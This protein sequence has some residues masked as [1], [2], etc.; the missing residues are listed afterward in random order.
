MAFNKR[1]TETEVSD[2]VS[3]K[4][5]FTHVLD[6]DNN[7]LCGISNKSIC[8]LNGNIIA[9]FVRKERVERNTPIQRVYES[10]YGEFVFFNNA[11][12]LNGNKVGYVRKSNKKSSIILL[13]TIAAIL[14]LVFTTVALIDT[15]NDDVPII[16]LIDKEGIIEDKQEIAVFDGMIKPGSQGVYYFNIYNPHY[17]ILE[18]SFSIKEYTNSVPVSNFPMQYKIRMNNMYII[19]ESEWIR[20]D[21]L[22]FTNLTIAERSTQVF[23]LEWRWPYSTDDELD[24]IFGIAAGTY[25]IQVSFTA[26]FT[27]E[28][29]YE[30]Q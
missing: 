18:Y 23:A 1:F 5:S 14:A 9:S 24:T 15:P 6:E 3:I 16:K 19:D 13:G 20:S 29:T 21:K 8:D 27:G 17:E 25:S 2:K 30:Q 7:L 10:K 22:T 28:I 4:R 11:L 12:F 26:E